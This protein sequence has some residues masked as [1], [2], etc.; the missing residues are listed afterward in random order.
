M[1]IYDFIPVPNLMDAKRILC[2]QPH[3]DDMDVACGGALAVLASEGVHITYLTVTDGG[4]GSPVRISE[5]QL[6]AAR[7]NEQTAAGAFIGVRDYQ[8]LD[9]PDASLLDAAQVQDDII[10]TI[11][12]VRPDT[13]FTVDPW[14]AYEAHPAH[15]AVGQAAAAAALFCAMPNISP[16]QTDEGLCAHSVERVVFAFTANAN[17]QID[18]T[19]VWDRKVKAIRTH[20]SQFPDQVWPMYEPYFRTQAETTGRAAGCELAENL[21]V[22]S[23]MHLHCNVDV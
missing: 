12:T 22:L 13:L 5:A 21:R 18:I 17:T 8:W 9:Y 10:R 15:R 20:H 4:A 23:P 16:E 7:R 3:P 11:R 2:V 1:S 14:L 19:K 6:A